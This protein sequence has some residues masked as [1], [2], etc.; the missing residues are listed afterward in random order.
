ML[1]LDDAKSRMK[2]K[3]VA[4]VGGRYSI[5]SRASY[6]EFAHI[7]SVSSSAR[8]IYKMS[9]DQELLFSVRFTKKQLCKYFIFK[10]LIA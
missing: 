1:Y 6:D 5:C 8:V 4:A 7:K 9:E 3:F 10:K 2:F